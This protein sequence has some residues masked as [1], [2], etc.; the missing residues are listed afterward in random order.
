MTSISF[1]P[2]FSIFIALPFIKFDSFVNRKRTTIHNTN[3]ERMYTVPRAIQLVIDR[4]DCMLVTFSIVLN[5]AFKIL[6]TITIVAKLTQK[7]LQKASLSWYLQWLRNLT[8]V[9]TVFFHLWLLKE[10][11]S[12]WLLLHFA[13]GWSNEKR[14]CSWNKICQIKERVLLSPR[15]LY[16]P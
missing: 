4:V 5:V 2:R 1:N 12:T 6:R 8:T 3:R 14:L 9:F 15:S 11:E 7:Q 16:A 13:W 10:F